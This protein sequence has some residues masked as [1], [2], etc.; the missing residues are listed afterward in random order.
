MGY[1]GIDPWSAVIWGPQDA[2]STQSLW[3]NVYDILNFHLF[4]EYKL[5][6]DYPPSRTPSLWLKMESATFNTAGWQSFGDMAITQHPCLAAVQR[7]FVRGWN[8]IKQTQ[9]TIWK[10]RSWEWD[11]GISCQ[12]VDQEISRSLPFSPVL[13]SVIKVLSQPKKLHWHPRLSS[14]QN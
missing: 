3:Q 1:L 8:P 10:W 11:L 12:K 9:S 2:V 7:W 13:P 5:H 14:V 6:I 4:I